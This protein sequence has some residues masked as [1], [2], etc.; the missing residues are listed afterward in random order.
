[1]NVS[2]DVAIAGAVITVLINTGVV[3]WGVWSVRK[4]ARE[5]VDVARDRMEKALHDHDRD[6]QSHANHNMTPVI[7]G[8]Q[9]EVVQAL[10]EIKTDLKQLDAQVAALRHSHEDAIANGLCVYRDAARGR[11]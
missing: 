9:L 5:E 1:M 2:S 7:R 10:A 11:S 3:S 8:L 4:I 6:P